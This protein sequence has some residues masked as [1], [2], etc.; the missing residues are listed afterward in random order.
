MADRDPRYLR[1]RATAVQLGQLRSIV[2]SAMERDGGVFRVDKHTG[3]VV[4]EGRRA[5]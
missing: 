2:E 4:A 1:D 5:G 3:V